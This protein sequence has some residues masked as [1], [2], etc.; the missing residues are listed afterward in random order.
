M[1]EQDF[2]PLKEYVRN[3]K[4]IDGLKPQ[5]EPVF[6]EQ[7]LKLI[8]NYPDDRE[9]E[10]QGEGAYFGKQMQILP[11]SYYG[12]TD[13]LLDFECAYSK[14][15]LRVYSAHHNGFWYPEFIRVECGKDEHNII[16]Q[17][18]DFLKLVY[19]L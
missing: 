1:Y 17:F 18:M 13:G 11:F 9:I 14:T 6:I 8:N 2:E 10:F 3:W 15:H 4:A 7:F 16:G 12:R 19:G 5:N